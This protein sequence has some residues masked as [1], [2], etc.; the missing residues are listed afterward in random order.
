MLVW[1]GSESNPG[2]TFLYDAAKKSL[3]GFSAELPEIDRT[4]TAAPKPVNY[5]ARD[6]Q[7]IFAYLTL[8]KGRPAK[9]L[10]LVI[11]PHGGPYGVRDK[12]AFDTEVQLLASRG[13]A[14]L[15]PNY[16]G[17]GGYGDA[18]DELGRGQIGRAMQDDLDDGVDWAVREGIVDK[19]RVCIMGGSYGG[20]AA[21][22]AAIRNPDRY[23]CAI[24]AAGV[25]DWRKLLK[26]DKGYLSREVNKRWRKEVLG[27]GEEA[28][29]D[30]V[31]PLL[32]VDR[33]TRPVLL[34]HGEDDVRVPVAQFTAFRDAAVKG[35]KPV[36]AI[37]FPG[38]GHSYVDDANR[39]KWYTAIEAFLARHNPAD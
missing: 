16:R 14:V 6:G 39:A 8:P 32:T 24:S 10:P 33:L 11:M 21:L 29:L 22:W 37:L 20:Y 25:T 18:F 17:S 7:T 23:R 12:L 35:G 15:Q 2:Q 13:Y 3:D 30:A 31:S 4:T 5:P 9:G 27:D 36:E 1:T 38:E 19:G 26:Y 28:A 34:S